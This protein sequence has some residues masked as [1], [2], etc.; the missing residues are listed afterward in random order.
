MDF[1]G[2]FDKNFFSFAGMLGGAALIIVIHG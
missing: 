2:I 1:A